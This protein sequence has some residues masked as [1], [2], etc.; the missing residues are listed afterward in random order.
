MTPTYDNEMTKMSFR[1]KSQTA[2]HPIRYVAERYELE[3]TERIIKNTGPATF[4]FTNRFSTHYLSIDQYTGNVIMSYSLEMRKP[5]RHYGCHNRL[6]FFAYRQTPIMKIK[7]ISSMIEKSM[8]ERWAIQ[9]LGN[10]HEKD[11][12]G[13]HIRNCF[14]GQTCWNISRLP[15]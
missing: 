7:G 3:C 9:I 2:R 13:A 14:L 6:R 12:P 11:R 15:T 8:T 1:C 10:V 5:P 4:R